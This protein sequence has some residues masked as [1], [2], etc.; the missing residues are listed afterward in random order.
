MRW[1]EAGSSSLWWLRTALK[2]CCYEWHSGLMNMN[3][4]IKIGTG[5]PLIADWEWQSHW[6]GM[7]DE[8]GN[9]C[10]WRWKMLQGS[11]KQPHRHTHTQVNA[12][13]WSYL[14]RLQHL[15]KTRLSFHCYFTIVFTHWMQTNPC[16]KHLSTSLLYHWNYNYHSIHHSLCL[17]L[18]TMSLH[19]RSVNIMCEILSSWEAWKRISFTFENPQVLHC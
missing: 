14:K 9:R 13:A 16:I 4:F 12:P 18:C 19:K 11:D 7:V 8:R 3:T 5:S 15:R 1:E 6:L 10:P 2:N 17:H